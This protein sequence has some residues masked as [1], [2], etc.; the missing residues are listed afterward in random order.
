MALR[1]H[2][3][4]GIWPNTGFWCRRGNRARADIGHESLR[5][6]EHWMAGHFRLLRNFRHESE[7]LP[8]HVTI[9][10][11]SC[12][13]VRDTTTRWEI[14]SIA[15]AGKRHKPR[16]RLRSPVTVN[17]TIAC[18]TR[19]HQQ[20]GTPTLFYAIARLLRIWSTRISVRTDSGSSL[21]PAMSSYQT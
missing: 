21:P 14:R 5:S 16:W 15:A 18:R 17:S 20:W 12:L 4:L 19:R 8:V 1:R 9:A 3:T 7:L 2:R 13:S 11:I 10:V 6:P